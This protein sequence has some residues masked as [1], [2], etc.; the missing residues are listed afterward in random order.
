VNYVEKKSKLRYWSVVLG[1]VCLEYDND[2][3]LDSS[4][5]TLLSMI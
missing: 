5:I 3:F 4:S 2:I 1:E